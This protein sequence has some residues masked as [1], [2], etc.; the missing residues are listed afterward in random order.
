MSVRLKLLVAGRYVLHVLRVPGHDADEMP[1]LVNLSPPPACCPPSTPLPPQLVYRYLL[2]ARNRTEPLDARLNHIALE[3][4]SFLI[5]TFQQAGNAWIHW[6]I[7][8][9]Q[10][11]G[12]NVAGLRLQ[13]VS[14]SR[15]LASNRYQPIVHKHWNSSEAKVAFIMSSSSNGSDLDPL[16]QNLDWYVDAVTA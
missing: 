10:C 11:F 2:C 16:W 4:P 1:P 8:I 6:V 13:P 7:P 12:N 14:P 15:H 5:V 9:D 3:I